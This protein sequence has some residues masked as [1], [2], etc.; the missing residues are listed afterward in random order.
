MFHPGTREITYPCQ[1]GNFL[2]KR[3][4]DTARR[5]I[6]REYRAESDKERLSSAYAKRNAPPYISDN[7]HIVYKNLGQR[8][9]FFVKVGG[10]DKVSCFIRNAFYR[11]NKP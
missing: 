6:A 5:V 9:I 10:E 4:T 1:R 7:R 3:F 11:S 2:A 8:T